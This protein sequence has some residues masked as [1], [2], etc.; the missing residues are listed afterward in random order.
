[1]GERFAH[2]VDALR[3]CHPTFNA[4][5]FCQALCQFVGRVSREEYERR[6]PTA[7]SPIEHFSWFPCSR[8][9]THSVNSQHARLFYNAVKA[10]RLLKFDDLT[11]FVR[12]LTFVCITT[13]ERGNEINR[14]I[15]DIR[16]LTSTYRYI[17]PS[18]TMHSTFTHSIFELPVGWISL[19]AH[20]PILGYFLVPMLPRGNT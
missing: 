2:L 12:E 10:T 8:V 19:T 15:T 3:L 20:P 4:R 13:R 5:L 14:R 7:V 1:M 11:A 16:K 9:G 18:P 17:E 6:K